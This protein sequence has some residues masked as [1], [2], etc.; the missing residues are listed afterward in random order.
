MS[1]SSGLDARLEKRLVR[2]RLLNDEQLSRAQVVQRESAISL[3]E[4]IAQLNLISMHD[5]ATIVESMQE[6]RSVKLE[7]VQIDSEAVRHIPA[8]VALKFACVPVR[9]SGNTIV[10]AMSD[11]GDKAALDALRAVTDFEIMPV[12]ADF[13]ALEH[14]L[15]IFYGSGANTDAGRLET[16]KRGGVSSGWEIGSP[17]NS[18]FDSFVDHEGV[19]RAR[20]LAKIVAAGQWDGLSEALVLVGPS[21]CGKSHLLSAIRHYT[22]TREPLLRGLHVHG[23]QLKRAFADYMLAGKENALRFEMRDRSLLLFDDFYS[24]WGQEALEEEI[25]T[26]INIV[27]HS[28]GVVIV[29]LTVEQFFGGPFS[30][31]MRELMARAT[32]VRMQLPTEDAMRSIVRARCGAERAASLCAELCN[33]QSSHTL[34]STMQEWALAH[35]ALDQGKAVQR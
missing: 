2:S 23:D 17:W 11:P 15:Y 21:G 31:A 28:S 5:L 9:R 12:L 33:Q 14:A 20:E 4:A 13:E 27:L 29:A 7:D 34:W 32:E 26:A 19:T 22:A 16:T 18:D 30:K 25:V 3:A 24:A 35:P 1:N 8:Q 6:T 10:V